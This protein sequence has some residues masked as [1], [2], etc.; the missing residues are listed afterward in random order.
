MRNLCKN[1]FIRL[2]WGMKGII[3]NR[4]VRLSAYA[5]RYASTVIMVSAS[6]TPTAA[7]RAIMVTHRQSFVI[8]SITA[9]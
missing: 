3:N 8:K 5:I 4:L 1:K 6:R 7:G 2:R 9:L